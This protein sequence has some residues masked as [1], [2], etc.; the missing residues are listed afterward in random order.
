MN[1]YLILLSKEALLN[2]FITD[3][4]SSS[5][6]NVAFCDLLTDHCQVDMNQS[7]A[8]PEGEKTFFDIMAKT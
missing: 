8:T 7:L 1:L 5:Q 2:L 6:D 4:Q 3:D